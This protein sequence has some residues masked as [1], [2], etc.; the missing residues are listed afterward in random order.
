M[1]K[2]I[3]DIKMRFEAS[4]GRKLKAGGGELIVTQL[5]TCLKTLKDR[6]FDVL[7]A[8]LMWF[9]PKKPYS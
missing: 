9:L 8:L 4:Q 3:I 2:K 7:H 1:G 5:Y 6:V